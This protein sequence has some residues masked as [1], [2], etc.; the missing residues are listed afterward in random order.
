[1]LKIIIL[2]ALSLLLVSP[3]FAQFVGSRNSSMGG[4]GV[5]SSDFLNAGFINPALLTQYNPDTDDDWGIL[6]TS[7]DVNVSDQDEFVDAIETFAETFDRINDEIDMGSFPSQVDLDSLAADLQA[8][9]NRVANIGFGTGFSIGVPSASFGAAIVVSGNLAMDVA[10]II[11]PNDVTNIQDSFGDPDLPDLNSEVT[12]LAAGSVEVGLAMAREFQWNGRALSIGITPKIQ[13]FEVFNY[14]VTISDADT[15]TDDFDGDSYRN[16]ETFFNVDLG[17][18]LELSER[19]RVGVVIRNAM[20]NEIDTPTVITPL[21]PLGKDFTY[22]VGPA[23]SAGIVWRK[24]AVSLSSDVD[25]TE[26][27]SFDHVDGSQYAR[28]GAEAAWRWAQLR[29]GFSHDLQDVRENLV[30]GGLGFSPFG[31]AH[32]D[33]GGAVGD[34][35]YAASLSVS[36]TF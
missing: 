27:S 34:E 12:I 13:S 23:A 4:V 19:L 5:A 22:T 36:L 33:L 28:V 32:V 7:I 3:A 29:M 14:G 15:A 21:S 9:N 31:V 20:K 24:G 25:L 16:D 18:T 2:T 17:A 35:T 30:S 8:L 26:R 11:D 10:P 6:L 1:M